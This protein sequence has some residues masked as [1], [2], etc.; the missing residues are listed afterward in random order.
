MSF[1][2]TGRESCALANFGEYGMAEVKPPRNARNRKKSDAPGIGLEMIVARIQQMMDPNSTVTHN[3]V[4]EDRVGNRR[5]YDVVIRGRFGGRAVL[6]VMECKDH[7]RKKGPDAV[8]AFAKKSENLGANLRVMVSRKGFTKQALNLAKHENIGCISLL[9]EDPK[10]VGFS[11]GDM[12]FGVVCTWTKI[13]LRIHFAVSPA[14]MATFDSSTV[15]WD[16]KPVINWFL[17]ELFTTH[18]KE[19]KE[20]EH[21]LELVF[22][23]KRN[24]EIDGK[25]YAVNGIT[26][27]A[28]RVYRKKR[29]WVNWTGDAFYDWHAGQFTIP[30]GGWIVGSAV[31]TDLSGWPD[32]DGDIPDV[33]KRD[34]PGFLRA[35]VYSTQ[36]WDHHKDDEVPQLT[37]L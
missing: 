5:Q 3:E 21:T 30:A 8:E 11:I 17:R 16:G 24:I 34:G 10:Q 4:L 12:W 32:Y 29:K 33:G 18:G 36:K 19:T 37:R 31:E 25:E 6:G 1:V 15:K 26:C 20:G 27:I 7:S 28:N 9:P 14:P 13:R 2:R 22:D 23:E 35:I